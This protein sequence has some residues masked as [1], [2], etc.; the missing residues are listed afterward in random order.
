MC[1][2]YATVCSSDVGELKIRSQMC[3]SVMSVCAYMYQMPSEDEFCSNDVRT[4]VCDWSDE[5]LDAKLSSELPVTQPV[6]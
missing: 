1:G 3:V 6:N 2:G 5:C 4:D